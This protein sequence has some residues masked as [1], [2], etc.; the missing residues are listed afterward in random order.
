MEE[1]KKEY[2]A[3][4]YKDLN[5][6]NLS[7]NVKNWKNFAS[8]CP[9]RVIDQKGNFNCTYHEGTMGE[10]KP[11]NCPFLDKDTKAELESGEELVQCVIHME[12][13]A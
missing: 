10:C 2:E 13:V 9:F 8:Q 5:Y 3:N 12:V 4:K 7:I 11:K 6:I 1:M